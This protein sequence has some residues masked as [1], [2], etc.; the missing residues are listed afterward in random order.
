MQDLYGNVITTQSEQTVEAV[1]LFSTSLIGFGT[2]FAPIFEASDADPNCAMAA[3]LAG[4]LG[5]FLETPERLEIAEKYF[6]RAISAAP[7][8]SEREQLFVEALWHSCKG[9]LTRSLRCFRRLAK[10]F[11]RDLLA[12]KIGQTHYFNLGDDEGMLWLA[13]QVADAHK[14]TAYLH[15]M[16][17]FGLE[18]MSRLEEAEDEA[19]LATH[20]QRREPWAH[21]AA[22]HVMLT[23]GRHDEGIK[24]M[25]DLSSEWDDCNSFMYTHNWWH[26]AVFYLELKEFD[27]TLELYDAHVW[28]R[29]K[30]YSQDQINAI[31]LLWRLEIA[32]V[33]LGTRWQDLSSWVA[34]RTHINDQP[35][36]DMQYVFALARGGQ[37][38]ELSALIEGM[39][40]RIETA[41]KLTQ[42]VWGNVATPAAKAFVSY[43]K[44][45]YSKCLSLLAPARSQLQRIGGS[46][47]QR[48]LFEQVWIDSLL[49][50]KRKSEAVELL[51]ARLKFRRPVPLDVA[52]LDQ[53]KATA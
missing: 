35:F 9:D 47:A 48:D 41:P 31:S 23:Q 46:H 51:E 36:L 8:A 10:E 34:S 33:D 14:D 43:A 28:G 50:A 32:G 49:K 7:G 24:W 44:G 29:D 37:Q 26:L 16:R 1:N 17:A 27:K 19:R 42:D 5:L 13:D 40:K 21:H 12:A 4:L 11:P 45:D 18:Q 38:D 15:G 39:E 6:K 2:D 3:G 52:W 22:A 53:A 30:A 20:M 25:T